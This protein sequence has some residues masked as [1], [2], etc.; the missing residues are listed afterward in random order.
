MNQYELLL[1]KGDLRSIGK[2][3]QVVDLMN[4]QQQ[5]DELFQLLYH[6]DRHLVMRAA[7]AIEKITVLHPQYLI[8][9]KKELITFMLH[10][11][12]IEFKWHLAL[13]ISRISLS[14]TELKKVWQTLTNW[15]L[16]RTESKIVRV[17]SLQTLFEL[18]TQH[19]Q[20][21]IEFN[22]VI[23]SLM[24]EKIPSIQARIKKILGSIK[25]SKR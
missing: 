13:M 10:A 19:E 4:D 2:S 6:A 14:K 15:A 1:K 11:I 23:D 7:D 17:N 5:F 20:L 25:N 12:H 21:K 8:A 18:S 16:D 22:L 9:H 24:K 3:N